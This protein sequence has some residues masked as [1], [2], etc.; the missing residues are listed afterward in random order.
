M[1][2]ER[3]SPA[4][5]CRDEIVDAINTVEALKDAYPN[6]DG[7]VAALG[8][9]PD[10]FLTGVAGLIQGVHDTAQRHEIPLDEIGQTLYID[11]FLAGVALAVIAGGGAVETPDGLLRFMAAEQSPGGGW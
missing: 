5:F 11:G 8:L 10:L 9:D 1:S 2:S 6:S 7:V 4:M 3:T